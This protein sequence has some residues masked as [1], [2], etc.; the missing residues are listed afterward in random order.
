M[1]DEMILIFEEEILQNDKVLKEKFPEIW[2]KEKYRLEK[3][4]ERRRNMLEDLK[5]VSIK[6]EKEGA[7]ESGISI[8][9][10]SWAQIQEVIKSLSFQAY[11]DDQPEID[12][13][14][15]ICA[16]LVKYLKKHQESRKIRKRVLQDIIENEYYDYYGCYDPMEEL[17]EALCNAEDEYVEHEDWAVDGE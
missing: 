14:W 2:S 9:G 6:E 5:S 7:E 15:D 3:W 17:V 4:L 13:I 12:E 11:I 8:L 16:A 1:S 10:S